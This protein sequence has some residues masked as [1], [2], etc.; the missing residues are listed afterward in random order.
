ML[1]YCAI[2]VRKVHAHRVHER[3]FGELDLDC[4]AG[5]LL[6]LADTDD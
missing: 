4:P 5:V 6:D 2:V 3:R 1:M